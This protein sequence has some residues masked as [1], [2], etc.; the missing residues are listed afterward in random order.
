M[1]PGPQDALVSVCIRVKLAIVGEIRGIASNNLFSD[2]VAYFVHT[3]DYT[4]IV[5]LILMVRATEKAY[6]MG[7]GPMT[8]SNSM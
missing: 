2:S 5:E 1:I 8:Q 4:V 3:K 6:S 7:T